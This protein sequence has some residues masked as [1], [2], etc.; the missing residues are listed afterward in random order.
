MFPTEVLH[1]DTLNNNDSTWP[2]FRHL[3]TSSWGLRYAV[4]PVASVKANGDGPLVQAKID[5]WWLHMAMVRRDYQRKG[6]CTTLIN[7][8]RD[9][10]CNCSS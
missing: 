10:V 5:S 3:L 6:I 1:A 2:S 7:L 4:I 9:K 8:V